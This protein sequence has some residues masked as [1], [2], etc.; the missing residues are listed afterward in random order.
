MSLCGS[1][2]F[3][4]GMLVL[5]QPAELSLLSSCASWPWLWVFDS[6]SFPPLWSTAVTVFF[7][8]FENWM[9]YMLPSEW[10]L[11][12]TFI[13][14]NAFKGETRKRNIGNERYTHGTKRKWFFIFFRVLPSIADPRHCEG[15]RKPRDFQLF[16]AQ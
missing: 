8:R 10:L 13:T 6:F 11:L 2:L 12:V 1:L 14:R 3:A 16:P 15:E 5:I 9:R 7:C 4:S